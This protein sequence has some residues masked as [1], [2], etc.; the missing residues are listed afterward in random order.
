MLEHQFCM[1]EASV[2]LSAC[3]SV[4]LFLNQCPVSWGLANLQPGVRDL[5]VELKLSRTSHDPVARR[6]GTW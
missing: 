1:Y 6:P 2:S 3:L 5:G 4:S